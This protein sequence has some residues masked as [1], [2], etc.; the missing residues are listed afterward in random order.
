MPSVS[1][2]VVT[3]HEIKL[4][5]KVKRQLL[6]RLHLYEELRQQKKAIELAMDKCKGEV[7]DLRDQTGEQTLMVEGFT[8]TLVAPIRKKF[9]PQ[10]FVQNGGSIELYNQS[11]IEVTSRAYTKITVPGESATHDN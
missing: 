1:P 6:T 3:T 5:N 2:A 4:D 9:D 8:V 11:H 10:L 7:E